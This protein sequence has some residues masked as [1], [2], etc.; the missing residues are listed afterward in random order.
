[1]DD[2]WDPLIRTLPGHSQSAR[3]VVSS[4]DG[5]QI[6]LRSVNHTIELWGAQ[7][8]YHLQKT[9]KGH[10]SWVT[11]VVYSLDGKQIMS[12]SKDYTIK[13]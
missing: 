12:G 4:P 9:L 10:S 8:G 13:L 3:A 11:A 6:S 1:M 7:T 2:S 5:R